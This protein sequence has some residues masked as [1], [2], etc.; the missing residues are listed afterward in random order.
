MNY[1]DTVAG[2]NKKYLEWIGSVVRLVPGE[3]VKKTFQ[4]KSEGRTGRPKCRWAE[5]VEKDLRELEFKTWRLK[6][7]DREEW[8]CIIK[9]VKGSERAVGPRS[10]QTNELYLKCY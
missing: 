2:I 9:Q 7:V 8:T 6:A 10:E 4:S 3:V 1:L 5:D